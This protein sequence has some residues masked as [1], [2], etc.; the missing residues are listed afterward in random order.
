MDGKINRKIEE[1]IEEKI[2]EKIDKKID[3]KIGLTSRRYLFF[4]SKYKPV[5]NTYFVTQNIK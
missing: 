3:K 2:K 1:K 5:K 4:H